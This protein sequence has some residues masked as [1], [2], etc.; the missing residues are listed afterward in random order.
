[1]SSSFAYTHNDVFRCLNVC[2]F[3]CVFGARENDVRGPDPIILVLSLT[4]GH[5]LTTEINTTT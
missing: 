5:V 4:A 3:A 1:M 2:V